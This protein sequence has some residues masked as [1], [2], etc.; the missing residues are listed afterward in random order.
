MISS[1]TIYSNYFSM[2]EYN[3][4]YRLSLMDHSENSQNLNCLLQI[5]LK[6][7]MD[8]GSILNSVLTK[9]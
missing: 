2:Y 8:I 7:V 3:Y 4:K 9:K 5:L 1:A 6:K